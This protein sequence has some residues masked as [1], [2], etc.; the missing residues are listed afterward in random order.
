[1][2]VS[3]QPFQQKNT[4]APAAAHVKPAPIFRLEQRQMD[5]EQRT[6]GKMPVWGAPQ[7][8]AEEIM[9]QAKT[10]P[11]PQED[12]Q[13]EFAQSLAPQSVQASEHQSFGFGDLIDM[14]NPLQHIPVLNLAYR[15]V[16]GDT[17]RPIGKI[18][19]GAVFGGPLGAMVG[20]A[21]ALAD[22]VVMA[23]TGQDMAGLAFFP[24]PKPDD[25]FPGTTLAVADLRHNGFESFRL[26]T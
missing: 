25:P 18:I 13:A 20:G 17:I 21:V 22:S 16:T 7:T 15:H 4:S 3:A 2:Q 8:V 6:A 23:E 1:M 19:G 10:P 9:A 11:G 26:N 24:E 5:G 12:P 14:I